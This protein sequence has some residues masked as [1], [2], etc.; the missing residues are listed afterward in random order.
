MWTAALAVAATTYSRRSENRIRSVAVGPLACKATLDRDLHP[1]R[2]CTSRTMSA[3]KPSDP[4]REL[5]DDD[6]DRLTY[7]ALQRNRRFVPQTPEEVAAAEAEINESAVELPP[8]L[9]DPLTVLTSAETL[10]QRAL[11]RPHPPNPA[12]VPPGRAGRR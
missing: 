3:D 1:P 5:T 11:R 9:R 6:A 7:E 12:R 4:K 10:A 8:G 2:N